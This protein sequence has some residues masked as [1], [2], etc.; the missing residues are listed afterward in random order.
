MTCQFSGVRARPRMSFINHI[1][2]SMPCDIKKQLF[3][4]VCLMLDVTNE[5][6]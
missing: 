4:D 6:Y 2:L 3:S 5:S 1:S